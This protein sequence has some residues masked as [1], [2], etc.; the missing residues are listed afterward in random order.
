MNTIVTDWPTR[1]N[2]ALG[3]DLMRAIA[4]TLVLISHW[5]GHF[6]LWFDLH[7][8]PDLEAA[9]EIGVQLFF[10]LSGFLIGRILLD[11]VR[12]RPAWRDLRV[13]LARRALRTMPLYFSWLAVL[14]ILFPPRQDAVWVGL[15]FATLTQNLIAPMPPD[16]YYAVSWSLAV[17]AWFYF[18]FGG[19][20]I[21]LSR[22]IGGRR[23]LI[24]CLAAFMLTPLAVRL[25]GIPAGD[26]VPNR[27][28]EIAYGVAMARL[29]LRGGG[30]FG[31][32]L[33]AL[34]A[35][36]VLI[37]AGVLP[38]VPVFAARTL[39]AGGCALCLPAALSLRELP[40][41]SA[42]PVRWLASRSYAIYL[43]HLT[44]LYDVV[45]LRLWTPGLVP[46]AVCAVLAMTLPL[47]LAELS[48]RYLEAPLLRIRPRQA[49]RQ[50][51]GATPAPLVHGAAAAPG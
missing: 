2:R 46:A 40:G 36:M 50:I 27:I 6:G 23:A 37:A 31:R 3:L 47:G 7:T 44:I 48:F 30:L 20:L 18:L 29:F 19:L 26:L 16:Y 15:R 4:V 45:E 32:P 51:P 25:A 12:T 14:L 10:A 8:G 24:P 38:G 41:W 21:A 33:T 39:A 17:E 1:D 22:W 11:I 42:A 49:P 35:G 28:D 5:G 34:A 43:I 13:F 9:G